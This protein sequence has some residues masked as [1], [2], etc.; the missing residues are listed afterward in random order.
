MIDLPTPQNLLAGRFEDPELRTGHV[1]EDPNRGTRLS[2]QVKSSPEQVEL[3]I[4]V[5]AEAHAAAPEG[6][7]SP[8][9]RALALRSLADALEPHV[10]SMAILDAATTGVTLRTTR[11]L[12]QLVPEVFRH[13]AL[14][15]ERGWLR[16]QL[17]AQYG[18]VELRRRPVG[19]VALLSPW[20]AP[21]A[22]SAHKVA[23]ALAAGAPCVL[24]PS[25]WAPHSALVLAL[26]IAQSD[27]PA[28]TFQLLQGDADVGRD[29]ADDPRIAAISYTGGLQGGLSV[30]QASARF[31]RPVQLELGGNNP[32]IV[33]PDADVGRAAAG[34]VE[35]LT[36]LGG[37][38]SRGLGRLVVHEEVLRPLLAAV[39]A[40]LSALRIGHSLD[41]ES[42]MGPLAHRAHFEGVLAAVSALQARGGHLLQS[43][44]LPELG[45]FFLAPALLGG[46]RP[47]DTAAEIFG[48]VA[49]VHS[50]RDEDEA[51]ALAHGTAYGLAAYVYAGDEAR[52]L[53]LARRLQIGSVKVNGVGLLA[54]HPDAPRSA[55][56][57]SGFGEEGTRA[58]IEAFLKGSTVGVAGRANSPV[59]SNMPGGAP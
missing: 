27:L 45:G 8:D 5:A 33:L 7:A 39:V 49:A 26:V 42:D 46:C 24:K 9:H 23:S 29:L 17:P 54:L 37:Q 41:P 14:E 31:L 40:R 21:A 53:Q 10:E 15:L 47:T 1:L 57:L 44:K 43:S 18:P 36:A 32:L 30:A 16:Q 22:V 58:S 6:W 11:L 59:P 2:E 38:W 13:A 25:E 55:W 52:G 48:P 3:A 34:V 35:A 4:A 20:N 51:L 19:P 12:A 50:F 56:G 28:G